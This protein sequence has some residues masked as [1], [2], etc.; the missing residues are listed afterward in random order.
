MVECN[1]T[2]NQ[3]FPCNNSKHEII[4]KSFMYT[5]KNYEFKDQSISVKDNVQ[6]NWEHLLLH[7]C[8]GMDNLVLFFLNHMGSILH[9][10]LFTIKPVK[11]L[12]K[13]SSTE[14]LCIKT[15]KPK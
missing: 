13:F 1:S 7:Q 10:K 9:N 15:K 5:V 11:I 4:V 6:L 14:I 3:L 2:K 12:C 8:W